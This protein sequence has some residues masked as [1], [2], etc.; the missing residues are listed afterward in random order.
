MYELQN[1]FRMAL[2]VRM[3][4]ILFLNRFWY[5]GGQSVTNLNW[6]SDSPS[7]WSR[8]GKRCSQPIIC[9]SWNVQ[10]WDRWGE[11]HQSLRI[12]YGI[13]AVFRHQETDVG[14]IQTS[15]QIFMIFSSLLYLQRGARGCTKELF[16]PG[17]QT[18]ACGL[19]WTDP[20]YN[21]WIGGRSLT[22]FYHKLEYIATQVKRECSQ[23]KGKS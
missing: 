12:V 16:V 23:A 13:Q 9:Y 20:A 11:L 15:R 14:I 1:G 5:A 21:A 10:F 22:T 18:F 6:W 8:W 3:Y 17:Q 4:W 2:R 19:L 7:V